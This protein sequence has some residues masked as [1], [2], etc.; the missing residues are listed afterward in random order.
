MSLYRNITWYMKGLREYT[1]NGYEIASKNFN[2]SDLDVDIGHRSYMITGANRGLGLFVALAIAKKGATVHIVCRNK[3][4]GMEAQKNI[5]EQSL[6]QKVH[7]H[8]LD[9]SK[10]GDIMAFTKKFTNDGQALNV[11]INNAGVLVSGDKRQVTADGIET[12]FATNTLGVHIL[13]LGLLP[14]LKNNEDPRVVIVSSGGMLVQKLDIRDLQFENMSKFDGTMAYAQTKRQEVVMASQYA[15]IYPE[16]YFSS[17]HPGWADTPGTQS[18][19]PDFYT[20]MKDRLRSEEQG[21]DTIIWLAISPAATKLDSGLFF[22][23]RK[24][25]PTHLPLAWTKSSSTDEQALM[26]KLAELFQQF[27][28]VH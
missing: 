10:P 24:P 28:T 14:V 6:N 5:Q 9:L 21:A 15:K 18:S 17:M 3:E 13:T 1:K 11:L 8:V 26:D 7:L 23:D 20:K 2:S 27:T 12:T 19:L 4:N 25:A 22:Q 16:I